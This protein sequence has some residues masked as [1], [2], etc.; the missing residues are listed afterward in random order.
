MPKDTFLNLPM[1]KRQLIEEAALDEFATWG[2]DNA[3]INRIVTQCQIAKGSFYQYFDD[4]KDLYKHVLNWI[5][6]RKIEYISPVLQNPLAHDFFTVLQELFRSGLAFAQENPKA[7]LIGN[8][9][10]KNRESSIYKEVFDEGRETAVTFY[11]NLIDLAIERGELRANIDVRFIT[12]ILMSLNVATFEY[13]FE[14]VKGGDFNMTQIDDD[15]MDT[16]NLFIDFI[17]RGISD[18][19]G[20]KIL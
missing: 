10:F 5:T 8:Q 9:V 13:Y 17:K 1:Q 16:V 18:P 3:S 7:A 20:E 19:V 15:Y 6:E 2:F 4:K 14:V 12:H 11:Q